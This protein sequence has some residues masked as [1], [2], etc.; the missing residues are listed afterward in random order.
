MAALS[1]TLQYAV[2]GP[3]RDVVNMSASSGR[4]SASGIPRRTPLRAGHGGLEMDMGI[5]TM[6]RCYPLI[7]PHYFMPISGGTPPST[8]ASGCYN[9]QHRGEQGEP[10]E[11]VKA[12]FDLYEHQGHAEDARPGAAVL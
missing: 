9:E 12:Q 7:E 5:W 1:V 10:P 4:P 2:F 8:A 11:D 6:D 3:W